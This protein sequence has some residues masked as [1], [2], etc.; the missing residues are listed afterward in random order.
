[1]TNFSRWFLRIALSIGLIAVV[2]VA[3]AKLD[4]ASR[5]RI[6]LGLPEITT[7]LDQNYQVQTRLVLRLSGPRV[8]KMTKEKL[9]RLRHAL[10]LQLAGQDPQRL[11]AEGIEATM[12]DFRLEA[13]TLI[14]APNAIQSV[15]VQNFVVQ[16]K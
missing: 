4:S 5:E 9:V 3:Q 10:V 6:Q 14:G 16:A 1:M 8:E 15:L 7:A 13:N 11:D 12:E 2:S